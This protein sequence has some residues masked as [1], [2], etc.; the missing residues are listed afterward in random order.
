MHH[1]SSAYVDRDS[2]T[3]IKVNIGVKA[4]ISR[5]LRATQPTQQVV[6]HIIII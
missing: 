1:K 5:G 4:F 3:I 6:P 2:T